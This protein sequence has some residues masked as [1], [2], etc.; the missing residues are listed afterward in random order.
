[1]INKTHLRLRLF[2]ILT[3]VLLSAF[4]VFPLGEKI[5]LGLDLKGGMY[6]LLRAD[7]TGIPKDKI[8]LAVEG[9][10]E[11]IRERIDEFGVKETAISRQ[12]DD[13][14]LVQIPGT[15]D[16]EMLAR[17]R[18]V[19]RLEFRLVEED[20]MKVDLALRGETVEGYELLEYRR[21]QETAKFLLHKGASLS[22]ADLA[23]SW[24]GFDPLGFPS[25][26]L[27]FTPQGKKKFAQL[28]EENVGKLLA[29][30]LDG[31][32][33]SAP[34]IH[35]PIT[36]GEAEITGDFS[37]EEARLLVSVLNSGALPVPLL[38]EEERS[39]GPLLGSDSIRR[40]ISAILLGGFLVVVFMLIYYF[41]G[42]LVALICLILDVIF[43][44]FGLRLLGA[45]LTL[46]GIAGIILTLGMAV[47]ANVLIYERIRE[48]LS[49]RKPLGLAIK[50]GFERSKSA[51]YDANITTII[52]AAFLFYFG[53]GPIRGF[54]TTLILGNLVS[55][56]TALWVGKALFALFLNMGLQR[57][58]M[59]E[60][61]K[62]KSIDF[63]K[64]R[65]MGLLL[66][67]LLILVGMFSFFKRQEDIYG[68]DFSGGQ[69]LEYRL[70]PKV[71]IERIREV[72]K[73]EGL[74]QLDIQDFKDIE[75][76]VIIR[77]RADVVDK[78]EEVLSKNFSGLERLKVN[79]VGPVVGK[80]LKRKAIL[81]TVFS[82]L[83]ILLY[84][85]LRFKH[86]DFALAGVIALFHD[87]LITLGF[88]SLFAYQLDLLI[89]TALL[90]IAGY[91]INDTIVIYDRIRELLPRFRGASLK[92]V[93]NRAVNETLSRTIITSLT[94]VIV[95][96]AIFLLGGEVLRG[97]SFSLLVGFIS[98]VY[99]TIYI[100]SGLVLLFRRHP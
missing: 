74:M 69:I 20:K 61:L 85:A 92:E 78:V 26:K 82:L 25:V 34:Q 7:T 1:M 39:V 5:N 14:I 75:G 68:V 35:E 13:Y 52:A 23:E 70:N 57:M 100:A 19:G 58:P 98:G 33:M 15:I 16:R 95:V 31:K 50:N 56:F 73:R 72:L 47:D 9:A 67:L 88:L 81:A 44:L 43:I 18:E 79:T 84:I 76:G 62:S 65:N 49:S 2:T 11:K 48:E 6:V 29:I 22:G 91:S 37:I 28:T 42:G 53:T 94:S 32:V 30:V 55:I 97:F 27:K 80:I 38:I 66:S 12:G 77:S 96:L 40:G 93:I 24:V 59:L 90:T 10:I 60:L 41:L 51:I 87:I 54:A 63:L 86:W 89:V 8:F 83:G 71:E 36:S 3:L 46:P 4:Y 21:Q 99:S 64:F 17:L 45:T